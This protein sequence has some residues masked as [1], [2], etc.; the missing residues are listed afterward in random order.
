MTYQ[1]PQSISANRLT[2]AAANSVFA[3]ASAFVTW[4]QRQQSR[5][6]LARLDDA[7]LA[8]IGLCHREA[9]VEIRKPFWRD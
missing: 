4:G 9:Q 3:L 1:N 7:M 5:R 2:P 8:D 6:A